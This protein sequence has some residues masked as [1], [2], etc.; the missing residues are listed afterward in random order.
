MIDEAKALFPF[1]VEL[2]QLSSFEGLEE[3]FDWDQRQLTRTV[4][5][6]CRG[7]IIEGP[8]RIQNPVSLVL[9]ILKR[10][11]PEARDRIDVNPALLLSLGNYYNWHKQE[12]LN[13]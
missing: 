12:G 6:L 3:E 5:D 4:N 9:S 7:R 1:L 10:K 11:E 13:S 2:A 8:E